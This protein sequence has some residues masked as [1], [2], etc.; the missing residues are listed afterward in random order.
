MANPVPRGV[1]IYAHQDATA[2]PFPSLWLAS[3][4]TT[5]LVRILP[6]QEDIFSYLE[7]FDC[8]A[9]SCS[10][11]HVPDEITRVEIERFLSNAESNAFKNPDALALLFA[12]L[13]QGCQNGVY[14]RCGGEWVKGAMDEE[15]RKGDVF[16]KSNEYSR[17]SKPFF[18]PL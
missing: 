1:D 4:G 13:A 5:A 16:S 2:D 15:S 7:A 8:R 11:P 6:P 10:F 3:H 14:D 12:A 17:V 18:D 9:Q